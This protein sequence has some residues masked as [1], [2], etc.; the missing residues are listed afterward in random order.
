M[1][2][3]I[4][5]RILQS[6]GTLALL[7]LLAAL[8]AEGCE[9]PRGLV[10]L[11]SLLIAVPVYFQVV[12]L[13]NANGTLKAFFIS[14]KGMAALGFFVVC[15]GCFFR[16]ANQHNPLISWDFH[17]FRDYRWLIVSLFGV[18]GSLAFLNYA[19]AAPQ[20]VFTK[21]VAAVKKFWTIRPG[22]FLLVAAGWVFGVTN[23]ISYLAFEH[24][25][26]VQ[27]TIAQLFQA[28]IF[29]QGSLTAPL[30]PLPEFFRYYY[31]NM[32]FTDRW[33]SQYPPVHPF[34]LMF[35]V[36]LGIPWIVNPILGACS[37]FPLYGFARAFVGE[38]EARFSV[39]LFCISPFVLF[40]SASY[41]NH[42][43]A[44]FFLLLFLYCTEKA[45]SDGSV[46]HGCIA[47]IAIGAMLNIRPGEAVV[48]GL[49]FCMAY[50]VRSIIKKKYDLLV[51]CAACGCIMV[52]LLLYYNFATNGDPLLFGYNLRWPTGHYFGFSSEPVMILDW[53][54]HSFRLAIFHTQSNSMALNQYLFEWPIPSLLPL[55]V[56]WT[57]FVFIKK[58]KLYL[59]LCGALAAP[60]F[61]F[62]YFFQDLCLGPRFYYMCLPF[63]FVLTAQAAFEIIKKIAH[64][65][66]CGSMRVFNSF[67]ALFLVFFFYT[68]FVRMPRLHSF[69]SESFWEINNA[70]MRKVQEMGI[71]NAL[72]FQKSYK[73]MGN[74]LGSGFLHNVPGLDSPVVFARD[75]GE[76]NR[77]L[78]AFFPER[79]LY[80]ASRTSNGDVVI[81]PLDILA[82]PNQA[83]SQQEFEKASADI[84]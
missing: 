83:A 28:K 64:I 19:L 34:L 21:A 73:Y 78:A 40:M 67:I 53:P 76:R 2:S 56:F 60:V 26:H 1:F 69:F 9:N 15:L 63:L 55:I 35:G 11:G 57:P 13:L 71:D 3:R 32:L 30:P 41:M 84:K 25:P 36:L 23:F 52:A 17:P 24:I 58:P 48:V 43:S 10:V 6:H 82:G 14:Y 18:L 81:E 31:D 74:D 5:N 62:F 49:P 4:L 51:S 46:W 33:Y 66:R 7:S 79:S 42:V 61:Y 54:P 38:N 70:L 20:G 37:V 47:G 72:I 39:L 27:D 75:L 8:Y 44:L 12:F 50:A 16:P 22:L 65:R 29:A 68:G 80:V 77:E 45:L 59:L